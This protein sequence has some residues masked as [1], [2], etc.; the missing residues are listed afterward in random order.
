M[1]PHLL[2]LLAYFA[3][4]VLVTYP[5]VAHF[6]T[7]VPGDLIADRDQNLW[8]LWWTK[9]ALA[10]A[11]NPFHTDM[12]YY[13]Y[14]AN[15]YYH[16]LALPLGLI[17]LIPLLLFGLPAAYN[18]VLLAAFTLSGYGAFRLALLVINQGQ[19][20]DD[21]HA[22]RWAAP[23]AFL[24]GVVFAFTPY[25]LDALKGQLEVLSLQW[26]P[27]YAEMWLRSQAPASNR[28]RS[29]WVYAALA[30]LFLALAAY[31]SLY[32]AVYLGIFTLAH[33]AYRLFVTWRR[34]RADLNPTLRAVAATALTTFAVA[35]VV[36]LPLALGLAA[37]R[38]NPRLAVAAD[39]EH[40]LAHSADLL[41]FFAPPHDHLLFG[42][43]QDRPGVNEP[44]HDYIALGYAAFALAVLGAVL[45][46]RRPGTPF[47]VAL[48]LIA[49]LLSMGPRL[50][51]DRTLTGIPLPFALLDNLPGMNA[52]AKPERFVVLARLCMGVLAALGALLLFERMAGP[53]KAPTRNTTARAVGV[54]ALVLVLLLVEL[55]IHPRYE[56]PL[57]L[58]DGFRQLA[59]QPDGAVMELPFATQQVE[60]TGQRMVN[61]TTHDKPI[62]S[63]YLARRYDSPIIDQC[64]PFW[65]FI[66]PLD[67]PRE[68]IA[69]PLVVS[70]PSTVLNFY[71][72]AYLAL[73]S[74]YGDPDAEPID[75]RQAEA[76]DR[77]SIEVAPDPAIYSDNYVKLSRIAPSDLSA[78]EPSFH[79]GHG[80]YP[81]EQS[82][83]KPFRW[84]GGGSGTL[85]VFA[86]HALTAP[87]SM[88]GTAFG[89]PQDIQV[90]VGGKR[91]YSGTLPAGTFAPVITAP[92]D[93]QPGVTEVKI[94][95]SG[96]GISPSALDPAVQDDRAL[97]VGFRGAT[98]E[99]TEQK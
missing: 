41:S 18:T 50:Q 69:S 76:F 77:I 71:R 89:K 97:T 56:E 17:G 59:A 57:V 30:G 8:N 98:L 65:G 73:Y 37:D 10:Q 60:I 90:S 23:A 55:P 52:I 96:P 1:L 31:S 43:W 85:C 72:I 47:W 35:S 95:A 14:G 94:G 36:V 5:A 7:Q 61:Q 3:L 82:D 53:R 16:T 87:L 12:L 34:N 75:P 20:A 88:E 15:L 19:A 80:W 99:S 70:Q 79:V 9:E 51:I 11:A 28:T 91:I 2:A 45:G 74:R 49:L 66:S 42:T 58:S 63:G 46:W 13:P 32:Y 39:P 29:R 83:G 27:F 92:V 24:G 25:T 21:P 78:A 62:M 64:S 86:P 81:I 4:A 93:W 84:L 26:M 44:P 68:D 38:D 22:A 48:A 40:R 33:V 54:F 67:V 6:I